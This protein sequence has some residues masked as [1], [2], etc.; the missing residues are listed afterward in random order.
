MSSM[1]SCRV[2]LPSFGLA[3]AVLATACVSSAR[4]PAA[5]PTGN[6][7]GT[8]LVFGSIGIAATAP[9]IE[10][11]TLQFRALAGDP[12]QAPGEFVFHSPVGTAGRLL[13]P[14]FDTPVDFSE[15]DAKGT[16][17]VAR[18]PAGD[19]A[20]VGAAVEN[21]P[22][23]GWAAHVYLA[24][25]GAVPF[26]VEAG[27]TTYLGQFISHLRVGRDADRIPKV[28]GAFFVVGDRLER[29]L[30]LLKQKGEKPL[31]PSVINL[32]PRLMQIDNEAL[33]GGPR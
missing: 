3:I 21:A 22:M 8:G 23:H 10:M 33:H 6:G 29:D 13:S 11:S 5:L 25:P 28:Q 20:L 14:L 32:A 12:R 30:A 9:T 19:Y 26:R 18:L 16:L 31:P 2:L 7:P 15:P 4:L 17:F 1:G 27:G 24:D